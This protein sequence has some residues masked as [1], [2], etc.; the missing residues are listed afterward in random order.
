MR[1]NLKNACLLLDIPL[2]RY[3]SSIRAIP[4]GI[5][6]ARHLGDRFGHLTFAQILKIYI[7]QEPFASEFGDICYV[8]YVSI[9]RMQSEALP[10]RRA[11]TTDD[12]EH[13]SEM[14]HKARMGVRSFGC[15]LR[16]VRMLEVRKYPR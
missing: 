15:H 16:L 2:V 11:A 3:D 1:S 12:L 5:K 7:D 6:D 14:D 9:L 8:A 4:N 13:H 10:I